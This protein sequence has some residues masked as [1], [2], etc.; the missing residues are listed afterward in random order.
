MKLV[1][2]ILQSMWHYDAPAKAPLFFR[3]NPRNRSGAKL[4]KITAGHKLLVTN[5]TSVCG[6]GPDS[7]APIDLKF[8]ERAIRRADRM[9]IDVL[10]VCGRQA[11]E[12][13]EQLPED[14]RRKPHIIMPH[15]AARNLTN[16]LLADVT[17]AL[18]ETEISSAEFEQYKGYHARKA[19]P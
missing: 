16:A 8:L 12:A 13:F 18:N 7:N 3:I 5:S 19:R 10:L 1:L 17:K 14:L 2:A 6:T 9:K 4:Y 11:K 15:P